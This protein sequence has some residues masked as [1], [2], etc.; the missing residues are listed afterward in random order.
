MN[1]YLKQQLLEE[2]SPEDVDIILTDPELRVRAEFEYGKKEMQDKAELG[3][4][5]RLR[6][7]GNE[8]MQESPVSYEKIGKYLN[9]LVEHGSAGVGAARVGAAIGGIPGALAGGALGAGA[10]YGLS[11][12]TGSKPKWDS[13]QN[14]LNLLPS[15]VASKLLPLKSALGKEALGSTVDNVAASVGDK[16]IGGEKLSTPQNLTDIG[17]ATGIPLATSLLPAAIR[18]GMEAAGARKEVRD[19]LIPYRFAQKSRGADG[20]FIT[21]EAANKELS[22]TAKALETLPSEREAY[23]NTIRNRAGEITS[24]ATGNY[25]AQ[26]AQYLKDFEKYKKDKSLYKDSLDT[27]TRELVAESRKAADEKLLAYNAAKREY[28]QKVKEFGP[29]WEKHNPKPKI[30]TDYENSISRPISVFDAKTQAKS[31]IGEFSGVPPTR[32]QKNIPSR[33]SATKQAVSEIPKS[34]VLA[35]GDALKKQGIEWGKLTTA[36]KALVEK[37]HRES[38]EKLYDS[39]LSALFDAKTFPDAKKPGEA[40]RTTLRTISKLEGEN[41]EKTV[42]PQLRQR[43]VKMAL[44]PKRGGEGKGY[45]NPDSLKQMFDAMGRE[46]TDAMFEKGFYDDMT[47]VLTAASRLG[48]IGKRHAAVDSNGFRFGGI[49]IAGAKELFQDGR[50]HAGTKLA[51]TMAAAKYLSNPGVTLAAIGANAAGGYRISWDKFAEA[52]LKK[53]TKG[54]FGKFFLE[55]AEPLAKQVTRRVNEEGDDFVT[56]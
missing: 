45:S 13:L 28:E 40:F 37:I 49:P 26:K 5:S 17:M 50:T 33:F 19:K 30:I 55:N 9:P 18:R 21:N 48:V 11:K 36:E 41:A 51:G 52:V 12:L 38:P 54:K 20:R 34:P 44:D 43:F 3:I 8:F 27:R 29:V 2:F 35:R 23:K 14:I 53:D 24:D 31:D 15:G 7:R 42:I 6:P 16:L 4:D 10:S 22:E 46:T 32:P 56:P 25:D 39:A 1:D 47:K